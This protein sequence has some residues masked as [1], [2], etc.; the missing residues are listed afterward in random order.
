EEGTG[1]VHIAAYG[2]F[3]YSLIK[4]YDL[5]LFTHV[6]PDGTI[7]GGH[8]DWHGKWFKKADPLILKNLEER[9]LLYASED[10]THSYPFCYRCDTPLFYNPMNSWFVRLQNVKEKL[11]Q[12]NN[13]IAWY[14]E[15]EGKA[16][17]VNILETAPDW[18]ISRNRYW[19]TALPVWKCSA[20]HETKI[21]GSIKELQ[22][23]AVQDVPFNLDL[24]KHVVDE[25][26]LKCT[27]GKEMKRIPEVI[28]CWFESGS[29]PFASQHYPFENKNE[30]ETQRFPGDFVSEYVGQ[31][32]AWFNYMHI[33]S[34]LLF[35]EAPFKNVVVSGNILAADG[36]KMS[37]SKGNFTD[38][39]LLFEKFGSDA[40]RFYLMQ[41]PVT[42]A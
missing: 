15:G 29:M 11:L 13:D 6:Q 39:N 4:K 22:Q 28:D 1:I 24:H 5:P 12:K 10:H 27:C 3:D 42:Q 26:T 19:A 30:F 34:V 36:N 40:V 14:P 25:I 20:C 35:D 8:E 21:V 18:N 23:H 33:L 32:R 37:K 16:R 41:S 7:H 38:P 9:K 31:V 17:F 2:E